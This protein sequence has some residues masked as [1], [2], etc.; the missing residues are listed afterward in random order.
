MLHHAARIEQQAAD[1]SAR[2]FARLLEPVLLLVFASVVAL[3]AAALLQAIYSVSPA[4]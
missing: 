4:G 1:R 2:T 3:V